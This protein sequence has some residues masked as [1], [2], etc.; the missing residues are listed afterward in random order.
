MNSF[1]KLLMISGAFAVTAC[2]SVTN[3]YDYYITNVVTKSH[4][5][6]TS[7][8]KTK[9]VLRETEG[10]K[11]AQLEFI[12][13]KQDSSVSLVVG[14]HKV[15]KAFYIHDSLYQFDVAD[16]YSRVRGDDFIRQMG[17]LSVF[18]THIP[19][20]KVIAFLDEMPNIKQKYAAI[21]PQ[22]DVT[23]YLNYTIA[24]DLIISFPKSK[25]GQQPAECVVWVGKRKHE[26]A[27]AQVVN[28]LNYI[29]TFN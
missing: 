12:L 26:L 17:D 2:S 9:L 25:A 19:A 21:T 27:T 22:K 3:V 10:N 29:R 11:K 18:F 20:S 6:Q 15:A 24:S 23:E 5:A 28:A 16:L 8:T 4:E 14:S 7:T 13:F 1:K